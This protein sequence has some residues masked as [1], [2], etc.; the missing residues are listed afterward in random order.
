MCQKMNKQCWC[1][2]TAVSVVSSVA[3][4]S[5]CTEV[6]C[7]PTAPAA[8]VA[9]ISQAHFPIRAE[10]QFSFYCDTY[11]YIY[12]IYIHNC[13]N[14]EAA[15]AIKKNNVFI[16]IVAF[17]ILAKHAKV[18]TALPDIIKIGECHTSLNTLYPQFFKLKGYDYN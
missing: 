13:Q 7:Y 5:A 12:C 8:V 1:A 4:S 11:K 2:H 10:S 15:G 14:M 18:T 17:C 9:A 6:R 3:T 16:A